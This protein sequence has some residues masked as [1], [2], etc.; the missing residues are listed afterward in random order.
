MN[1]QISLH[2]LV[3]YLPNQKFSVYANYLGECQEIFLQI[4]QIVERNIS[5]DKIFYLFRKIKTLEL[6]FQDFEI[7]NIYEFSQ[8]FKQL[9]ELKDLQISLNNCKNQAIYKV[10][11]EVLQYFKGLNSLSITIQFCSVPEKE[12]QNIIETIQNTQLN[13]EQINIQIYQSLINQNSFALLAK[14][15]NNLTLLKTFILNSNN[16]IGVQG[17]IELAHLIQ[18]I[19]QIQEL[20]LVFGNEDKI[21]ENGLVALSHSIQKLVNLKQLKLAILKNDVQ[22][23]GLIALVNSIKILKNLQILSLN[24]IED[25]IQSEFAEQFG[26]CLENLSSLKVLLLN[27]KIQN[28]GHQLGLALGNSLKQLNNLQNLQISIDAANKIQSIGCCALAQSFQNIIN[29]QKLKILINQNEI[30]PEGVAQIGEGLKNLSN[31]QKLQLSI[32]GNQ[33][34]PYGAQKLGDGLKNLVNLIELEF[35]ISQESQIQAQGAIYLGKGIQNLK[36]L[37]QLLFSLEKV[38]LQDEGIV[39]FTRGFEDLS[40]L[41]KLEFCLSGNGITNNGYKGLGQNIQKLKKIKI[42]NFSSR[43]YN[44]S[45]ENI[46]MLAQGFNKLATLKKLILRISLQSVMGVCNYLHQIPNLEYIYFGVMEY[47]LTNN[48]SEELIKILIN[49]ISEVKSLRVLYFS[50]L[51]RL[52]EKFISKNIFRK[53]L[54]LVSISSQVKLN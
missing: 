29:L 14:D 26:K 48:K 33:F 21:G 43:D 16:K 34:L 37:K 8:A 31:L 7:E 28:I 39:G 27:I 51:K 23:Q 4:T 41:I 50:Y 15:I 38:D 11:R 22:T 2:K 12:F 54:K 30:G 20:D 40:N 13:L 5:Y 6:S 53:N 24:F 42:I 18:N 3:D 45:A 19:S 25:N 47:F 1:R 52:Q 49:S 9:T 10:V 35:R 36:N 46:D 17:A 44:L 32:I